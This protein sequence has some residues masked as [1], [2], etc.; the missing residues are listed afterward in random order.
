MRRDAVGQCTA[1]LPGIRRS[2]PGPA[3]S[4]AGADRKSMPMLLM[5]LPELL[6]RMAMNIS[7]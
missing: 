3:E 5:P 2:G 7:F 4:A 6:D 1:R